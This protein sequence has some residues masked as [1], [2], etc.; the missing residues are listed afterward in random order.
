MG[1]ANR[2]APSLSR[3]PRQIDG[4]SS[5]SL[6]VQR[7]PASATPPPASALGGACA[8]HLSTPESAF[9]GGKGS[10]C[11]CVHSIKGRRQVDGEAM[12]ANSQHSSLAKMNGFGD[13]LTLAR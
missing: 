6:V 13:T 8:H 3:V 2:G 12:N 4:Q 7:P 10:G 9:P 11:V 5:I 1:G